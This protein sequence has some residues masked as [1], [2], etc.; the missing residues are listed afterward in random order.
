[1][2]RRL[3]GHLAP[4]VSVI[5]IDDAERNPS[6][7]NKFATEDEQFIAVVDKLR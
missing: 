7:C 5:S 2:A 4:P 1:L 3:V 6:V